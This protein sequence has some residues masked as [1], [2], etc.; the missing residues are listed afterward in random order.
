MVTITVIA[1]KMSVFPTTITSVPINTKVVIVEADLPITM[2]DLHRLAPIESDATHIDKI[3]L[4]ERDGTS[5]WLKG[6]QRY[7]GDAII[8]ASLVMFDVQEPD[9]HAPLFPRGDTESVGSYA[10][11]IAPDIYKL[12][13][14]IMYGNDN[15]RILICLSTSNPNCGD[16]FRFL[17][18]RFTDIR[19]EFA[20]DSTLEELSIKQ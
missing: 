11:R 5:Y 16:E 17:R 9:N 15:D 1:G 8:S 18:R 7:D 13:A 4:Y 10:A 19:Y 6:Y 12:S 14:C 2:E 3:G 20:S